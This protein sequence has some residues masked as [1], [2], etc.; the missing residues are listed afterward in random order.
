MVIIYLLL[1]SSLVVYIGGFSDI[2]CASN[3]Y[4]DS[5]LGSCETCRSSLY[6]EPDNGITDVNGNSLRCKCMQGYERVDNDCTS[7][8]L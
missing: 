4:F 2:H 8:E 3:Q 1:H 7:V 5:I 6:Q